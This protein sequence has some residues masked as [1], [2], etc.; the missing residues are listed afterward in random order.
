MR[1]VRAGKP[2]RAG[3]A[4][5]GTACP[6]G[7][8]ISREGTLVLELK[9]STQRSSDLESARWIFCLMLPNHGRQKI[10]VLPQFPSG[11]C[12]WPYPG[13]VAQ[14]QSLTG[15][16]HLSQAVVTAWSTDNDTRGA[17]HGQPKD[18]RTSYRGAIAH[19]TEIAGSGGAKTASGFTV[20][21]SH[22]RV[23]RCLGDLDARGFWPPPKFRSCDGAQSFLP[24]QRGV[25]E[26]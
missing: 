4:R 24:L 6:C 19:L 3:S 21:S 15:H 12:V 7:H 25:A 17:T 1:L 14:S 10:R 23:R 8:R 26:L 18:R 5:L 16:Q 11:F 22:L 2:T 13:V 20:S 9:P